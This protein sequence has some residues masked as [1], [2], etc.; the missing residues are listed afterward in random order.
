MQALFCTIAKLTEPYVFK[1]DARR[2]KEFWSSGPGDQAA[3]FDE[4]ESR[5]CCT[6]FGARPSRKRRAPNKKK[7][8]LPAWK[9]VKQTSLTPIIL[10]ATSGCHT[11]SSTIE[12]WKANS[13]RIVQN[14]FFHSVT[15]FYL[16]AWTLKCGKTA[17]WIQSNNHSLHLQHVPFRSRQNIPLKPADGLRIVHIFFPV[18]LRP[19]TPLTSSLPKTAWHWLTQAKKK[20]KATVRWKIQSKWD[21]MQRVAGW[22]WQDRHTNLPS[23]VIISHLAKYSPSQDIYFFSLHTHYL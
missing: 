22:Q 3:V 17:L 13:Y 16:T 12:C 20:K 9:L 18:T 21:R 1:T 7:Q 23:P 15:V 6:F 5:R 2:V 14:F 4:K 11:S 19:T 8:N 10:L